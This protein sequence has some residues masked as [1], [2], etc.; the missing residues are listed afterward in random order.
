MLHSRNSH[1]TNFI[2]LLTQ[3]GQGSA[4]KFQAY[5]S[6]NEYSKLIDPAHTVFTYSVRDS[7]FQGTL[8]DWMRVNVSHNDN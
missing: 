8:Y 3:E 2:D 7:G 6:D 1:N 4:G 5:L